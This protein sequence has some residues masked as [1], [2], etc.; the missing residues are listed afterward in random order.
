MSEALIARLLRALAEGSGTRRGL[1][2]GMAGLVAIGGLELLGWDEA[3]ARKRRKK[4]RKNRRRRGK[5]GDDT[6][7]PGDDTPPPPP[8]PP[9]PPEC[10]QTICEEQCVDL[11][12]DPNNCGACGEICP[13]FTFCCGGECRP[14]FDDDPLNCGA[15]GRVCAVDERCCRGRCIGRLEVCG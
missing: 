4:K 8:P 2:Q 9:P 15:C 7:P 13:R 1:A 6:P 11:E 12:I 10:E 5:G 14:F 3:D